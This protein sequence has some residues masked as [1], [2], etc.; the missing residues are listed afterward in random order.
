MLTFLDKLKLVNKKIYT[1]GI[2]GISLFV[3]AS[4][5]GGLLIEDYSITKQYI[6]ESY[7]IDTKYGLL[8]RL[9]GF[10]PSGILFSLFFFLLAAN[11]SLSKLS[12]L[13][14]YGTAIFYGIGTFLVGIF[15]CD[16]GCNKELINPSASQ[17]IHN[18]VAGLTYLIVPV[19]MILTGLGIKNSGRANK[20]ALLSIF[21]GATNI[22]LVFI[23]LSDPVTNISGAL[24][25]VIELV[26]IVWVICCAITVKNNV[27]VS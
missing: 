25:R 15:P 10:I 5:L 22:I 17:L 9:F 20:L 26:F 13:G 7:A 19:L 2:C 8:L 16:S 6:S 11:N 14:F 21:F 1:I 27:N 23:L 3:C 24:Q 4:I 18:L 12:K